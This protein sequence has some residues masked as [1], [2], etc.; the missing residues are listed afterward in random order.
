MPI[1]ALEAVKLFVS[2]TWDDKNR[3]KK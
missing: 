1:P 2:S 3:V